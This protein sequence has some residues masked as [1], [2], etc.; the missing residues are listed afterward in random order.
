M[1]WCYAYESQR[2]VNETVCRD[3]RPIRSMQH[4]MHTNRVTREF[5]G[6]KYALARIASTWTPSCKS[7]HSNLCDKVCKVCLLHELCAKLHRPDHQSVKYWDHIFD[8]NFSR[9]FFNDDR[10]SNFPFSSQRNRCCARSSKGSERSES[11]A[12]QMEFFFSSHISLAFISVPIASDCIAL[13]AAIH[14]LRS[15]FFTR[16]LFNFGFGYPFV[17]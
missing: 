10:N 11:L 16:S 17:C 3:Q 13:N 6:V 4:A 5:H 1:R 7:I 12:I 14:A 9:R 15:M 8:E 2:Q